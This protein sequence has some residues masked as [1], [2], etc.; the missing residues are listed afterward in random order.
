MARQ[1]PLRVKQSSEKILRP[2]FFKD[3]SVVVILCLR[4]PVNSGTGDPCW[5]QYD[6]VC[7]E[8]IPWTEGRS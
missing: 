7:G 2:V 6:D 8:S 3:V 1:H 4:N 5:V